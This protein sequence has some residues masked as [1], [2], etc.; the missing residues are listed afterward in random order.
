LDTSLLVSALTPETTTVRAQEWLDAQNAS[1]FAISDWVV[2]EFS[3]ALSMKLRIGDLRSGE[4]AA[5]LSAFARLAS[6]SF[7]MLSVEAMQ[8]RT[9][10]TFADHSSLGIRGSDALHLAICMDHGATLCTMDR[11]LAA[12]APAVGVV[13]RLA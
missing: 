6:E 10:A 7:G 5:A 1:E 3:A 13:A 9:A 12:A 8:F 2:T 4:R 11:R